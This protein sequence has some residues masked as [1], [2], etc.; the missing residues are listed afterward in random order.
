MTIR[1]CEL[2]LRFLLLKLI[3]GQINPMLRVFKDDPG[4]FKSCLCKSLPPYLWRQKLGYF[5]TGTANKISD[6]DLICMK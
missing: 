4:R 6:F 5:E 1:I 3:A 2:I